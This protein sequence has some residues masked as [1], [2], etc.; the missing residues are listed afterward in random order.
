[1]KFLEKT[2]KEIIEIAEPIW[3]NL[4]KASNI[5]DYGGFTKDF[6]N[7]NVIWCK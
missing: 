4:V 5:K 6:W 1:M 3:D 7:S 2:D